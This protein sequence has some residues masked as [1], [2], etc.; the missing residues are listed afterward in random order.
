MLRDTRTQATCVNLRQDSRATSLRSR[1]L[2]MAPCRLDRTPLGDRDRSSERLA[3]REHGHGRGRVRVVGGASGS[4]RDHD[5][6]PDH[7]HPRR[8]DPQP[9]R[10]LGA[11]RRALARAHG[12]ASRPLV[13]ASRDALGLLGIRR[14]DRRREDVVAGAA[15]FA[16]GSDNRLDVTATAVR[17]LNHVTCYRHFGQTG[18]HRPRTATPSDNDKTHRDGHTTQSRQTNSDCRLIE[19]T[20]GWIVASCV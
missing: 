11:L 7:E 18:I 14:V 12:G 4:A 9:R 10:K 20:R 17:E 5:D 2:R 16:V 1:G 15:V 19:I 13:I 3:A 6:E 8:R